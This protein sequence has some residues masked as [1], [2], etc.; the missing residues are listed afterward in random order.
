MTKT[1]LTIAVLV[2]VLG[3]AP[4]IFAQRPL[5]IRLGVHGAVQGAPDVIAI[6]QGYF[7]QEQLEVEWRRF[8][9]AVKVVTP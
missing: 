2:L 3:M 9:V 4:T 8:G 6:R 5:T 1:F 7:K